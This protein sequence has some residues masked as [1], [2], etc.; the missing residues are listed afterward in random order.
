MLLVGRETKKWNFPLALV[1]GY[2]KPEKEFPDPA[3]SNRT[4]FLK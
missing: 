3:L 1:I 2:R 4:R